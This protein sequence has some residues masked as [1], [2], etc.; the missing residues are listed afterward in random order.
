MREPVTLLQKED[1]RKAVYIQ[2]VKNKVDS[3]TQGN[4]K[5]FIL[6]IIVKGNSSQKTYVWFDEKKLFQDAVCIALK[7]LKRLKKIKLLFKFL[8]RGLKGG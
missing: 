3:R 4:I 5:D 1:K 8:K 7:D 6:G 2:S